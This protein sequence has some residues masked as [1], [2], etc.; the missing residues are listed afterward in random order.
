MGQLGEHKVSSAIL[1]SRTQ[2]HGHTKL[3]IILANTFAVCSGRKGDGP[4]NI[5]KSYC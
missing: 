4:V 3:Q 5:L 2:L 1:L